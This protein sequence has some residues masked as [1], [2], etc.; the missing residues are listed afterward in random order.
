[1]WSKFPKKMEKIKKISKKHLTM[2]K[3][4]CIIVSISR[5]GQKEQGGMKH[6]Y[7]NV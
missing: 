3:S 2:V 4:G 5:K 1:M 7:R 6:V